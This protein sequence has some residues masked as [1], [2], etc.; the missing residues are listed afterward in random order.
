LTHFHKIH[1]A[2]NENIT[3]SIRT[4]NVYGIWTNIFQFHFK[5]I[6]C[7]APRQAN[8]YLSFFF[9]LC[10]S[11]ACLVLFF[12]L[13]SLVCPIT[14]LDNFVQLVEVNI[15]I[16]E[17]IGYSTYALNIFCSRASLHQF[18][19]KSWQNLDPTQSYINSTFNNFILILW[20]FLF[21]FCVI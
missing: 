6:F 7:L 15:L 18:T 4:S 8:I 13:N 14:M 11:F 2:K 9:Y 21:I 19:F 10:R 1:F 12:C 5:F 20:E 3:P 17:D 16:D